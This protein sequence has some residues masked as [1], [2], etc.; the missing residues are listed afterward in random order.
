MKNIAIEKISETQFRKVVTQ[1][2]EDII[3]DLKVLDD[4]KQNLQRQKEQI[5]DEFD[6]RITMI[7]D[8]IAEAKSKGVKTEAEAN[9][10]PDRPDPKTV[11]R[12]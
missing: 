12:D 4:N 2:V 9:K 10:Q 11:E 6:K 5:I 7:E 8:Q 3:I 1:V